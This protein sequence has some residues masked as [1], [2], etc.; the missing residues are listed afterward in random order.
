MTVSL[1]V[2][3]GTASYYAICE[4]SL[5]MRQDA[6]IACVAG[7]ESFIRHFLT[8]LDRV[9]SLQRSLIRLRKFRSVFVDW[10]L[11]INSQA[12]A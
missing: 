3:A 6:Y 4:S 7:Q 1:V 8:V 2:S 5:D 10:M 11:V 9:S 12:R